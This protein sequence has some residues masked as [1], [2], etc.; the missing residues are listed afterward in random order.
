M[1]ECFS[2]QWFVA[3]YMAFVLRGFLKHGTDILDQVI[4]YR[5]FLLKK[6]WNFS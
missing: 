5:F 6:N 2:S 3:T 1:Y 4:G